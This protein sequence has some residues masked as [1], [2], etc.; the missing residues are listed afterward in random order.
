[1]LYLF[2]GNHRIVIYAAGQTVATTVLGQPTISS[3]GVNHGLGANSCDS[4][5]LNSPNGVLF[6]PISRSLLVADT[7]NNRV[8]QFVQGI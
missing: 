8:L 2:Q 5:S 3:N 7:S 6:N 1:M 4:A